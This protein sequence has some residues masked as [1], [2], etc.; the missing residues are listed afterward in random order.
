MTRR[1]I[2]LNVNRARRKSEWCTENKEAGSRPHEAGTRCHSHV[3]SKILKAYQLAY[4]LAMQVFVVS[5]NFPAGRDL[6]THRS[7][8]AILA[9]RGSKHR[10]R[11]SQTALPKHAS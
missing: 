6:L 1:R 7:D 9:K 4:D 5:K 11:I 8:S 2:A 10:G 3:A